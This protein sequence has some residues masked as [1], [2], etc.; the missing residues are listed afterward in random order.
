MLGNS[1][2]HVGIAVGREIGA[3]VGYV[4]III[5]I[6]II[7][8]CFTTRLLGGGGSLE[9]GFEWRHIIGTC[10]LWW[11]GVGGYHRL[12]RSNVM[13]RLAL[14]DGFLATRRTQ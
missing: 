12:R 1:K 13:F 9:G 4:D 5:I 10:F 7:H 14:Q 3:M 6:I 2:R 11:I 8:R